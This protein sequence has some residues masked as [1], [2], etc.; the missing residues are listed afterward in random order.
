M[1]SDVIRWSGLTAMLGG[2]LGAVLSP[3]LAHLSD[4]YSYAYTTYGRLYFL[5]LPPEL[6]GLY[7]LRKLRGGGL[8]A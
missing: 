4:I 7:V 8:G 3:I 5:S 1:S 2:V 6:L